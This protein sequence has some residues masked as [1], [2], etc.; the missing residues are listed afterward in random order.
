L[1]VQQPS[2]FEFVIDLEIVEAPGIE[3]PAALPACADGGL[4]CM[5][6][7]VRKSLAIGE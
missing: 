6:R 5:C 3:I 2:E 7:L 4:R 1:P